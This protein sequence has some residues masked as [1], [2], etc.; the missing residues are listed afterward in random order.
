MIAGV[1]CSQTFYIFPIEGDEGR[2]LLQQAPILRLETSFLT[3]KTRQNPSFTCPSL[4]GLTWFFLSK[5][6]KMSSNSQLWLMKFL[7]WYFQSKLF[8]NKSRLCGVWR[9]LL[10]VVLNFS[11]LKHFRKKIQQTK[12]KQFLWKLAELASNTFRGTLLSTAS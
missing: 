5:P 3:V 9:A 10:P 12:M 4:R 6:V 11:R 8:V 1:N 7:R 2:C